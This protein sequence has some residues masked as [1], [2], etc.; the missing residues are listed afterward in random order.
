MLTLIT[1]ATA[2]PVTLEEVIAHCRAPKDT[3]DDDVLEA[4]L[5][6]ATAFVADRA[7][8]V[9]APASYRIDRCEW[10]SGKLEILLK[11]VREIVSVKYLDENGAQQ[12]VGEENYRLSRT[13][14]GACLEL[15]STYSQPAVKADAH[16][17]VQI[18]LLAGYDDP[19]AT[20]SGDDPELVVPPQ[21][22]HA[23]KMMTSHWYDK[24]EAVD[25]N[26]LMSLPLA[27]EA[28]IAQIRVYR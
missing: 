5:D 12:T 10:W 16:N 11:P 17:A 15:L 25:S 14:S 18:E 1:A 22:Q 8:L 19:D 4:Y 13:N 7:N 3:S 2:G 9:L 21:A 28:L 26:L 20:G 27:V 23:I 6:A 24:R